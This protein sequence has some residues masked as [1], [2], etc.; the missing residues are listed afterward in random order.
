[1]TIFPWHASRMLSSVGRWAANGTVTATMSASAAASGF[2]SPVISP[3]PRPSASFARSSFA[4]LSAR[5]AARDPMTT[6]WPFSA[7]R[8][9]S[10]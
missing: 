5:S 10:P 3:A 4:A 6:R 2:T 9:A 1:M 8:S 7:Q